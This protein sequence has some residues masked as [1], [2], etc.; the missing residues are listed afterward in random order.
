MFITDCKGAIFK[1]RL[2]L[3][4]NLFGRW[5]VVIPTPVDIE[6]DSG[7]CQAFVFKQ[8]E[9]WIF[10]QMGGETRAGMTGAG[11]WRSAIC[12]EARLL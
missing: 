3:V 9:G 4:L 2:Q 7:Y 8:Q 1:E 12:F 10:H 6:V 11:R 5:V